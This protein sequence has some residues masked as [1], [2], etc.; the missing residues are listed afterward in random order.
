MLF[1]HTEQFFSREAFSFNLLL[2]NF[3]SIFSLYFSS[4]FSQHG[5]QILSVQEKKIIFDSF[6]LQFWQISNI[7]FECC[8]VSNSLNEWS[9]YNDEWMIRS[10]YPIVVCSVIK[11]VSMFILGGELFGDCDWVLQKEVGFCRLEKSEHAISCGFSVDC[12]DWIF[13][14][15]I[16]SFKI[17]IFSGLFLLFWIFVT[18]LCVEWIFINI[19]RYANFCK[20]LG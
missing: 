16:T 7:V 11:I 15:I 18:I 20:V 5:L 12:V 3:M 14:F 4:D 6:V 17:A 8:M 1:L 10:T 19:F 13:G 9:V 2:L